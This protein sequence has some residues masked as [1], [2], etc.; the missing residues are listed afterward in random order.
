MGKDV[1]AAQNRGVAR[2]GVRVLREKKF[3]PRGFPL[4]SPGITISQILVCGHNRRTSLL[5][6]PEVAVQLNGTCATSIHDAFS[7]FLYYLRVILITSHSF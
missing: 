6:D 7:K 2:G 1:R 3:D 4:T 5:Y